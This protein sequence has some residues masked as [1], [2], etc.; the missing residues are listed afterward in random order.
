[1]S[2]RAWTI[3]LTTSIALAV[4]AVS[5]A[6]VVL[7]RHFHRGVVVSRTSFPVGIVIHHTATPPR[8]GGR[9]VDSAF[10]D[11]MHAVRSFWVADSNG[12]VYHIGY[13]FLIMQDGT[14]QR[15]RPEHLHGGHARGHAD[16]LGI[17]LVGNFHAASNRGQEGPLTPPPAQLLAT[18]RLTRQLMTKYGL[19]PADVYLHRDLCPTAC[20]GDH[21]P[22]KAFRA[23]LTHP[24]PGPPVVVKPFPPP[25]WL[26]K[27]VVKTVPV[28]H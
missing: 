1:M 13:H 17:V 3:L 9:L 8:V 21:F 22:E 24:D 15:G 20:P 2:H 28:T 27:T 7:V 25:A 5:W 4:F 23:A 6:A 10:I 26:P 19:T 12:A 18:E 14:V 16:M 11:R